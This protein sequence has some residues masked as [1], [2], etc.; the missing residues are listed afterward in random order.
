[1]IVKHGIV[2]LAYRDPE[3]AMRW[4][5]RL[6]SRYQFFGEDD[7]YVLRYVG[8]LAAQNRSPLALK[9]LSAVS[10]RDDYDLLKLWRVYAALWAGEWNTARR[11]IAALPED[12]RGVIIPDR[13]GGEPLKG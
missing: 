10:V 3:E 8:I 1:M 13:N 11:F 6:K 2:R 7:D 4:W 9:W 12:E 5:E